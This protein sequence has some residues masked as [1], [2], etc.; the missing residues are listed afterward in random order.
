[1]RLWSE[2]ERWCLEAEDD[3]ACAWVGF[4]GEDLLNSRGGY[5]GAVEAEMAVKQ[6]TWLRET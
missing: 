5:L 2:Q 1:M 3:Q 6:V 4:E